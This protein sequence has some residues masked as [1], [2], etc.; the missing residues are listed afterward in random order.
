MVDMPK[1]TLTIRDYMTII[2]ALDSAK[3]E[4]QRTAELSYSDEPPE[5]EMI[6]TIIEKVKNIVP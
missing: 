6:E 2:E 3:R 1:N 5:V 4:L